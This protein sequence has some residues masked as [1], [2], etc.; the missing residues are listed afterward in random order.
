MLE[1]WWQA[2]EASV[3]FSAGI[4]VGALAG[5]L[6]GWFIGSSGCCPCVR[7]NHDIDCV[8]RK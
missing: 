2:N 3:I 7:G 8:R 4:V 6:S 1:S 5:L